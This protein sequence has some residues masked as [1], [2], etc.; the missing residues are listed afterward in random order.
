MPT[1]SGRAPRAEY[2]WFALAVD[3]RFVVATIIESIVGL[4]RMVGALRSLTVLFVVGHAGTETSPSESDACTTPT[5]A[6]GGS[7][8]V[9]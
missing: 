1:F 3:H 6:A 7:L 4:E 2:W 9:P 5:A 8:I